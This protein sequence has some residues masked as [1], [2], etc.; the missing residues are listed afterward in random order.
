MAATSR[1]EITHVS[2][3]LYESP[4][5]GSVMSL[6]LEPRDDPPQRLLEFRIETA[7]LSSKNGETDCFGN[8]KHV[9]NVHREHEAMEIVAHST[10]ETA[11]VSPLSGVL[12]ADAWEEIRSWKDS[13]EHWDV[14]HPSALTRPS[15]RLWEFVGRIGI[16]PDGHP[17]EALTRLSD[18]LHRGFEYVPGITSAA[19][20][21][22]HVLETGRGVC[23]D[24]A[25]VMLAIARSWGVPSRYVSGYVP[26]DAS[27]QAT[28][29][30]S[31]AWVE[32]LLP[33]LGWT[34]F[35]PTN[36]QPPG[37]SHVR[38]AVGRDYQDVAPTRGVLLGG[39]K[40]KLEVEV[41]MR[42]IEPAGDA[43]GLY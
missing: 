4:V 13:F 5:R 23:Q 1:Y 30:A 10:V 40:S 36:G 42:L 2:R 22:D 11:A 16:S 14:M 6:C 31:H 27:G 20:P 41:E 21:I 18:A 7:P 34:G 8:T 37:D 28:E 9:M 25:H 33:G 26:V 29:S 43:A 12:G 24:Y 3:Y 35:D 32:C 19:S 39:G 17:L 38:V 15:A